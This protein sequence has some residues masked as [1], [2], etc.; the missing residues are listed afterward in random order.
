MPKGANSGRN[1][2]SN[3]HS[4]SGAQDDGPRPAERE[5]NV[6]TRQSEEHSRT[7]KGQQRWGTQTGRR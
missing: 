3:R 7:E 4:R 6:R 5:R 2:D 1:Q